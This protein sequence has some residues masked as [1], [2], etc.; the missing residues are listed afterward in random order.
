MSLFLSDTGLLT[1]RILLTPETVLYTKTQ[2]KKIP[3][4]YSE[5]P[6]ITCRTSHNYIIKASRISNNISE[7]KTQPGMR[8][9]TNKLAEFLFKHFFTWPKPISPRLDEADISIFQVDK[10]PFLIF[11]PK[12]QNRAITM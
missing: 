3:M 1:A 4:E 5:E 10:I 2:W 12:T 8:K 6:V 11:P 9:K 7:R